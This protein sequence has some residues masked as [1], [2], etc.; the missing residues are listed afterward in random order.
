M[1]GL[2][3]QPQS[4]RFSVQNWGVDKQ[5]PKPRDML[6]QNLTALMAG[7]IDKESQSALKRR[8]GV[9]QSTIGR[10]LK[11]QVNYRIETVAALAKAFNLE[12]WQLLVPN[13]DPGNLP[14]L[15]AASAQEKALY[16]RLRST[17]EDLSKLKQ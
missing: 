10:I 8:S 7:K 12:P 4:V 17:V 13:L 9:A 11:G 14:I 16:E 5:P 3:C 2:S 15:R 6:A 1:N